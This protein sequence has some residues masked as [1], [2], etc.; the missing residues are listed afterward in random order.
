MDRPVRYP[1]GTAA[2]GSLR[3]RNAYFSSSDAAF[4]D[5]YQA[6]TEW[7]GVKGGRIA[8]DGGWRIYSSGPDQRVT[9]GL[10]FR[11]RTQGDRQPHAAQP[12][13][14]LVG[15]RKIGRI[16]LRSGGPAP[17]GGPAPNVTQVLGPGATTRFGAGDDRFV[18]D[19]RTGGVH[20]RLTLWLHPRERL[21]R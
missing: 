13:A 7:D 16:Y 15:W 8:V 12:G 19:G 3:Q 17:T 14:R 10:H 1:G 18:W 20:H 11:H 4:G 5:R 2:N 21:W 9:H 6:E